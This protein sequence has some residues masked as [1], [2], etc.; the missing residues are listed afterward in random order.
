MS[1]SDSTALAKCAYGKVTTKQEARTVV[2]RMKKMAKTQTRKRSGWAKFCDM[3]V[4]PIPIGGPENT[5]EFGSA[6]EQA[7]ATTIVM[8]GYW[9]AVKMRE[10]IYDD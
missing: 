3:L 7:E 6:T 9:E 5:E 2:R 10:E 4:A 1:I 8:K